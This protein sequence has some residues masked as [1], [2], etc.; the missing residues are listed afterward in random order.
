MGRLL[1]CL[2]RSGN[3]MILRTALSL[4]GLRSDRNGRLA[5]ALAGPARCADPTR[6]RPNDAE[7]SAL[8]AADAQKDRRRFK[9]L[10]VVELTNWIARRMN[11]DL[12]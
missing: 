1:W 5:A 3:W 4:P 2:W 8:S 9:R 11:T 10:L 7:A 12:A 6:A